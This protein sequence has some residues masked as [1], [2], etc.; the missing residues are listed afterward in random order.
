[1]LDLAGYTR[2]RPWHTMRLLELSFGGGEFLLATAR[3]AFQ[4][5]AK[6]LADIRLLGVAVTVDL[7]RTSD[8]LPLLTRL[9]TDR[10]AAPCPS[11]NASSNTE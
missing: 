11:V 5:L 6:G 4:I 2:D 1:M 7:D 3:A 9:R 8:C 10:Y